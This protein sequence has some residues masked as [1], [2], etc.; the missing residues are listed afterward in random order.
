[1]FSENF[2]I[3]RKQK[4]MSQETLAQQ[5]NIVRQTISKWEKGLSVP[6]ADMLT[7]IAE[8]FEVS[9]SELLGSKIEEEK[10]INEIATQLALLNEQLAIRSR[11]NRKILK[12]ILIGVSAVILIMLIFCIT[13][14][15][16]FK[17][18]ISS[19]VTTS[20]QLL[21][22]L[23]GKE[24]N[25]CVTYDEQY[26]IISAG[27]DAFIANHVQTEEYS[28]ANILIAQIEDYFNDR[29]GS[30]KYTEETD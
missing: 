24:Y 17:Y 30:V 19:E 11:R 3:L 5:L 12:G 7:Q 6:D 27:G 25:Y 20:V 14:F 22:T 15:T 10:N 29:G 28:D 18:Q 9:V 26:N 21:C 16:L 13:A 1:M 8:L 23:D 2:K 4:G